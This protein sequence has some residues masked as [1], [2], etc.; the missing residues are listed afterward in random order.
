MDSKIFKSYF[1]PIGPEYRLETNGCGYTMNDPNT[2]ANVNPVLYKLTKEN[3]AGMRHWKDIKY[4]DQSEMQDYVF[5]QSRNNVHKEQKPIQTKPKEVHAA[6]KG[7]MSSTSAATQTNPINTRSIECQVE[8]MKRLPEME[9]KASN[10]EQVHSNLNSPKLVP[11]PATADMLQKKPTLISAGT[12]TDNQAIQMT[13]TEYQ[14]NNAPNKVLQV[15]RAT[16]TS[17]HM[18][19]S[20]PIHREYPQM[21]KTPPSP[22]RRVPYEVITVQNQGR[23][24]DE[25]TRIQYLNYKREAFDWERQQSIKKYPI[26]EHPLRKTYPNV[27]NARDPLRDTYPRMYKAADG[28]ERLYMNHQLPYW[29]LYN[30]FT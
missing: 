19:P 13:P 15:S 21:M 16:L 30:Y 10:A 4:K 25:P 2:N 23:E 27:R 22:P 6:A 28:G 1:R 20:P 26:D 5:I 29:I 3:H 17:P 8:I 18:A 12:M 7:Q 24:S 14:K 11:V 9:Q